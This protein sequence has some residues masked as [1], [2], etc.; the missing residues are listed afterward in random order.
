M[1]KILGNLNVANNSFKL[2][3]NFDNQSTKEA[4]FAYLCD[5]LEADL[6]AKV[7]QDMGVQN[8]LDSQ[9]NN[10]VFKSKKIRELIDNGA[11]TAFDIWYGY[12][13]DKYENDEI[14]IKT[15]NYAKN[16]KLI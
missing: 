2:L 3:D 4:K 8:S 15:L 7:Y 10:V 9:G 13:K 6:Q 16:N 5:K 12:D 14:F 1:K 11:E